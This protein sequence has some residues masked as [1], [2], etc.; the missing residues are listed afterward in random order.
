MSITRSVLLNVVQLSPECSLLRFNVHIAFVINSAGRRF[1][2]PRDI[3]NVERLPGFSIDPVI[4][5]NRQARANSNESSITIIRRKRQ[6][7]GKPSDGRKTVYLGRSFPEGSG[8][9]TAQISVDI[10]P[11]R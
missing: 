6:S 10:R 11:P 4:I 2:P 7:D 3:I 8:S 9:T 1:Q 5:F